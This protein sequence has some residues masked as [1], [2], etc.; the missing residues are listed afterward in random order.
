MGAEL[1]SDI[2]KN[3]YVCWKS[4]IVWEQKDNAVEEEKTKNAKQNETKNEAWRLKF[5]LTL[6]KVENKIKFLKDDNCC[7]CWW[8]W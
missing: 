3:W 6:K 1:N 8:C 4:M 5:C 2:W 7:W